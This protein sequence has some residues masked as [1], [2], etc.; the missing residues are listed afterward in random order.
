MPIVIE[1]RLHPSADVRNAVAYALG[2]LPT[3]RAPWTH[4]SQ[5]CKTLT[6]KFVIRRHSD[7]V[8]RAISDSKEIRDALYQRMTD[9]Q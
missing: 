6:K 9:P 4:Y 7:W 3:I 5:S 8:C 1:H 2:S